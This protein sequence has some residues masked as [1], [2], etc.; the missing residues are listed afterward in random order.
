MNTIWILSLWTKSVKLLTI[1]QCIKPPVNAL[2]FFGAVRWFFIY[3]LKKDV[4]WRQCIMIS[5]GNFQAS[6]KWH[7]HTNKTASRKMKKWISKSGPALDNCNWTA[8]T[9]PDFKGNSKKILV[10]LLI[11][12]VN[13]NKMEFQ[14]AHKNLLCCVNFIHEK[15]FKNRLC[16]K[17]N[18]L[19]Q[20]QNCTTAES[21]MIVQNTY[22]TRDLSIAIL[23]QDCT[24]KQ[25]KTQD[26]SAK[27]W[28]KNSLQ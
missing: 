28:N 25:V 4:K 27:A 5:Q 20:I 11:F 14:F 26:I 7:T 12:T 18:Y 15:Q 6:L 19:T 13:W 10:I 22:L 9:V 2:T 1:F 21:E 17:V 23:I 3:V 16:K 24:T 8:L